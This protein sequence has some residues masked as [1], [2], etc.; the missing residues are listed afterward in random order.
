MK[1]KEVL[2][3]GGGL[4]GLTAAI[5]L[6]KVGFQITVVE[7]NEFPKHKVCGEYISNEVLPYLNWLDLKITDLCPTAITK[8][9]FST[10]SGKKIKSILPLGGFGISRYTLDEH[11]CTKAIANGCKII[12]D[13]VETIVFENEIFTVT[14]L[15]KAILKSE[16][17]IGSFGKRSTIDQKLNRNFIQKKSPWLA[18]KAHYSGD[19]PSDL[20]GLYNFKGGYCGV[21]KVEN[22]V[23]NIC[24]LADYETFKQFKNVDEYQNNVVYQNPHLKTIFEK[25]NLLFEKPLTI[26]QI[27]FEKKQAVENHIL[28]IGDTAGLIHPLCGNG[29]AMAIHSAKI[30]SELLEKYCNNE[31]KSRNEL[32]EKYTQEWSFNFSKR[33]GMG[34][35]LSTLLQKKKLSGALTYILIIFPF[36][37]SKIIKKTHGTP[38]ILNS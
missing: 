24:Y 7:K 36:L 11:L 4:A 29:M 33:L 38:I 26:S 31:I 19:F 30:V 37:L 13:T 28:M 34:R 5:H 12:P 6:S 35:F 3:I 18:V 22:D 8:L 20:V 27:S 1:N 9:E 17:V 32:E 10:V 25:S 23:I 16:I 15:N 2:I 21:S 14:T